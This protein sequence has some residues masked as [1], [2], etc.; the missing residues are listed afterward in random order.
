MGTCLYR[1]I[2]LPLSICVHVYVAVNA[3][4]YR[5]EFQRETTAPLIGGKSRRAPFDSG[6]PRRRS[7]KRH[8]HAGHP[9]VT[10]SC[11]GRPL[12][13]IGHLD[14]RALV[15]T[16]HYLGCPPNLPSPSRWRTVS[17][18]FPPFLP[19]AGHSVKVWRVAC[20]IS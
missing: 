17:R 5:M 19:A 8:T 3:F 10:A 6:M 4:Q 2:Y 15:F 13:K 16:D 1:Q 9:L 11:S 14:F 12:I 20:V 18:P 7:R